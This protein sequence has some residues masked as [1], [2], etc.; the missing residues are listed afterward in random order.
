M[1]TRLTVGSLLAGSLAL[2]G[3]GG[4]AFAATPSQEHSVQIL[5]STQVADTVSAAG[6][7]KKDGTARS[8]RRVGSN[9]VRFDY[10]DAPYV[11]ARYDSCRGEITVYYGGYTGNTHYNVM[12][13]GRQ[14]EVGPGEAKKRT[15][16][17]TPGSFVSAQVQSCER[18]RVVT[19]WPLP[20]IRERSTC[21]RFSPTVTVQ[22]R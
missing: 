4:A 19:R 15:I 3:T 7:V 18:G 20:P 14:S 2:A 13:N 16:P 11:G 1:A 6:C 8:G 21:T 10:P 17:V 22:A 5:A 12:V 9:P